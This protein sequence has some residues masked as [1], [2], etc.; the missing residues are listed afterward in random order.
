MT[1]QYYMVKDNR[2]IGPAA[3]ESLLA[4]GLDADTLVWR[5]GLAQWVPAARLP[6]VAS[7]LPAL[8]TPPPIPQTP[9]DIPLS[10]PAPDTASVAYAPVM[11]AT[12]SATA[13]AATVQK[14]DM[15]MTTGKKKPSFLSYLCLLFSVGIFF[16]F[17][18][19][20]IDEYK[21]Y[22]RSEERY[23]EYQ[24]KLALYEMGYLYEKPY[25]SYFYSHPYKHTPGDVVLGILAPLSLI[26][27]L[28]TLIV[29][30]VRRRR[31]FVINL[32]FSSLALIVSMIA[33]GMYLTYS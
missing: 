32:I 13:P 4:Q 25:F 29:P 20:N 1:Q 21:K 3:L 18:F 33:F 17:F 14:P 8:P 15:A 31:L 23:E 10:A 24:E 2:R 28:A 7:L 11:A 9:P 30:A 16:T 12:A 5:A 27:F 26:T 22:E 6:E 19:M